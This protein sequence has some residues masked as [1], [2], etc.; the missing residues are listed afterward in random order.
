MKKEFMLG[1]IKIKILKNKQFYIFPRCVK[2]KMKMDGTLAPYEFN[3][4][5]FSITL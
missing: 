1:G 5:F 2:S 4:T 3:W